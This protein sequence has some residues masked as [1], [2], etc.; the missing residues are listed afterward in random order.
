MSATINVACRKDVRGEYHIRCVY[1]RYDWYS[2]EETAAKANA[3]D[4]RSWHRANP[5]F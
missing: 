5:D 3:S 4:H 2:S 1:C